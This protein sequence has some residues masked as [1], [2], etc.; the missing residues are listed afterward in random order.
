MESKKYYL[1]SSLLYERAGLSDQAVAL[2]EKAGAWQ[3]AGH[4]AV[5]A[6]WRTERLRE[7][8]VGLAGRMEEM[9]RGVESAT[10]WKEKLQVSKIF[11]QFF[12]YSFI[13]TFINVFI[14]LFTHTYGFEFKH[15]Y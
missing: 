5:S 3:R 7:L 8:W 6:G 11:I 15:K 14:P 13:Y 12:I 4:L 10:I 9:D 2:A 1:E